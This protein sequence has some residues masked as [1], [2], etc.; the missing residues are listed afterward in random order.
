M[1]AQ[2]KS[3]TLIGLAVHAIEIEVDAAGGLPSWDIVGLPDTAVKESKER[4]RTAIK[5]AGF[6]FPPRRI[7]VNLAPANLKKEGPSFDLA[8]AIAILIATEQIPVESVEH[9]LFLG[10][11]GLDGS[12]RPING[13]LPISLDYQ[14]SGLTLIVPKENAEE[15]AIGKTPTLGF[16]DLAQVVQFLL[17]TSNCV[18]TPAPDL[19]ELLEQ[20]PPSG[21]DFCDIKGQ[22]E[23]K[24]AL[25]IAASGGHNIIMIGSPGSGK[26][27]LARALPSIMPP[28]SLEEALEI[29]KLYSIAG[30]L[31]SGQ[32]LITN[33][34]FR[35]PHH[36]A[37][38]ASIIGGGRIPAPG[39]V[40]LAHHGILFM[41]EFPEYRKD[42]LE[43]LRQPLEDKIVTI[44]RVNAQFTFP[45]SFLL[46]ASMNPC[47]CGYL[48]DPHRECTCTPYQAQKYRSKISGPLLDRFDLQL[49]VV[50]LAYEELYDAQHPEET[51]AQIRQR[52]LKA[53]EIQ[54]KRFHGQSIYSNGAMTA[55][56]VRQ[57]CRLD[58]A[59]Q[60]L[61]KA[62]FERLGLSARGHDRILK[63]ARTIAD[64]AD[65][66]HIQTNHL[67]EAIQYRALDKEMWRQ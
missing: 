38:S 36:T 46:V 9:Y 60:K 56:M 6:D 21:N 49:E 29:T 15:G 61:L 35:S 33:R 39:E 47:P 51:S 2:I 64:L 42:V 25:T 22:Q 1:L 53:R 63:V 30:L 13:V 16:S 34:P 14:Q 20:A 55:P 37:S 50:P 23:A 48:N 58:A 10:E 7:V 43:S 5:N 19:I 4:V 57:Y 26:T 52:V 41:D 40:S 27:M 59:G 44:S 54:L 3:S 67:A 24:R 12:L 28:L 8:I 18:P 32:P 31:P 62:A 45:C 11:L 66:E 65:S 17:G